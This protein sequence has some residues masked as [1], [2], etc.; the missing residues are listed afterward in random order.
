VGRKEVMKTSMV[1]AGLLYLLFCM[2]AWGGIDED[3]D[4]VL[5]TGEHWVTASEVEKVAYLFGLGNMLE[6]EQAMHGK[7]PA[8][9]VSKNSIVPVLID[10][11]SHLST[12]N[13]REMLDEWYGTNPD[14]LK[15]P[16]I[17]VLYFE[18]ALPNIGSKAN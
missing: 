10:G 4:L 1:V 17:D 15:R 3:P 16:V 5:L 11:L 6:V 12:R 9:K 8:E 2:A 14:Q 13:V 7:D 18:F